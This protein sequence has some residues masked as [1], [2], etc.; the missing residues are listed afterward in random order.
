ML[1]GER[2]KPIGERRAPALIGRFIP[3]HQRQMANPVST[4]TSE[5]QPYLSWIESISRMLE[6]AISP[7]SGIP[8]ENR[9]FIEINMLSMEIP[10]RNLRDKATQPFLVMSDIEGDIKFIQDQLLFLAPF[11]L[12]KDLPNTPDVLLSNPA[13]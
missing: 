7:S 13:T 12:A 4:S 10:F 9:L 11:L 1:P 5:P 2:A 8:E 3:H 6:E